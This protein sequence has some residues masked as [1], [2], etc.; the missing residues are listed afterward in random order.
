MVQFLA[1]ITLLVVFYTIYR[2]ALLLLQTNTN[3]GYWRIA[4]VVSGFWLLL[5]ILIMWAQMDWHFSAIDS[6]A[7]IAW[8]L[9]ALVPNVV[10][11][12]LIWILR[13]FRS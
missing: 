8:I 11:W 10:F 2:G 3:Q 9:F 13:G 1:F 6:D 12:A 5:P 4:Y 7:W